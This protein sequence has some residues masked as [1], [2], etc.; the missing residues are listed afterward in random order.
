[1]DLGRRLKLD[2]GGTSISRW[3]SVELL[4]QKNDRLVRNKLR[5]TKAVGV[6][7]KKYSG[8]R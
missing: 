4:V 8:E 1:M 5:Y 2:L 6:C 3:S 7:N